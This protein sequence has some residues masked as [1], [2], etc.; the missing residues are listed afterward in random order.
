MTEKHT[1]EWRIAERYTEVDADFQTVDIDIPDESSSTGYH[2][3]AV[4]V[5]GDA[6]AVVARAELIIKS[7]LL[8]EAIK[9]LEEIMN[10]VMENAIWPDD[11]PEATSKEESKFLRQAHEIR[12]LIARYEAKE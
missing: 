8:L 12:D 11:D 2:M 9:L 10:H 4:Q 3:A 1:A 7:P 5:H 6:E